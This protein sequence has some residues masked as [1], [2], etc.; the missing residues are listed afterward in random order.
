[1]SYLVDSDILIDALNGREDAISLLEGHSD[2]QLGMSIIS[3]GEILD[4]AVGAPDSEQQ[5][6]NTQGFL[7]PFPVIQLNAAVMLQFAQLRV[8]LRRSG[9]SI[10]DFDLLIAS[11]AMVHGLTIMTRNRRHFARIPGLNLYDG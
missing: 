1:M 4:G 6:F 3:L 11:T 2:E 7:A 9:Q 8:A 10:P 5:L